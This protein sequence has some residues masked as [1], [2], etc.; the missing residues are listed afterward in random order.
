MEMIMVEQ[1]TMQMIGVGKA[2]MIGIENVGYEMILETMASQG[3]AKVLRSKMVE[4][5]KE[6]TKRIGTKH[7]ITLK[8]MQLW[9]ESMKIIGLSEANKLTTS[10]KIPSNPIS[11]VIS[12]TIPTEQKE[13]W[14][15]RLLAE[16]N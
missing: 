12:F 1:R 15:T 14:L 13:M 11:M 2:D 10:R 3:I 4:A 8:F 9:D 6:L 5:A 16:G 7:L